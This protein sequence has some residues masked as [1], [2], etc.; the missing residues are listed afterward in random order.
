MKFIIFSM[1]ASFFLMACEPVHKA[2]Q[3]VGKPVGAATKAVGGVTEG[4]AEGYSDKQ[5]EN[6]Y[7]R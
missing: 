5:T 2:A 7:N 1:I 6:P 3:E 4:A